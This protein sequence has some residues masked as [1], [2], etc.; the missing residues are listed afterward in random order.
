MTVSELITLLSQQ[1]PRAVVSIP[2]W[3]S[4]AWA[5]V[6]SVEQLDDGGVL[7]SPVEDRSPHPQD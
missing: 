4:L 7:L 5:T 2:Q 3:E 1:D 6:D